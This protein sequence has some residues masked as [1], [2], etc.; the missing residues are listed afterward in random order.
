MTD[1]FSALQALVHSD[2]ENSELAAIKAQCLGDFFEKWENESLVVNQWLSLQ[3]SQ[4]KDETLQQVKNLQK[5]P[6][7]D[8]TNPNTVRAL[9]GGFCNGSPRAFH[10]V[11]GSGYQ[12][13]A[14]EVLRL[15]ALNP[16]LAARL[17]TPLTKWS[18]YKEPNR[19]LMNDALIAIQESKVLS[20]DVFE[21]ISKSIGKIE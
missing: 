7:Y 8:E 20:S 9:V 11:D 10:A 16:Q 17:L 18:R 1:Q 21:V 3:A 2:V 13:L 12:F 6:A 4:N 14:A 19:S 15:D 5:H